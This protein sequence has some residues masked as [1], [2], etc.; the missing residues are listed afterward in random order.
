L[1]LADPHDIPQVAHVDDRGVLVLLDR[2]TAPAVVR[3]SLDGS[4]VLEAALPWSEL[5]LARPLELVAASTGEEGTGAGDAAPNPSVAL[6][7][8]PG[9]GSKVRASLDRWLSIPADGNGDGVPDAGV[10]PRT[11]VTVRP[12]DDFS[13]ARPHQSEASLSTS[14]RVFAPDLGEGTTF[15]VTVAFDAEVTEIFATARVYSVDGR[16]V[17]VLYQDAARAISGTTVTPSPQDRWDGRDADGRVVPG[18][19]YVISFEWG[20]V[21]GEHSGRATAG[22]AVAR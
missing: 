11:A 10:S 13:G 9:P 20:L 14:P 4:V 6:P 17:R 7:A 15:A 3:A 8:T 2:A 19:I 18:G 22:V 21:R 12:D 5:S 16:L 1:I